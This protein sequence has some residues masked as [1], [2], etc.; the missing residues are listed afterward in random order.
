M[1]ALP[2]STLLPASIRCV[3]PV[4]AGPLG[5][6]EGMQADYGGSF[7]SL[8]ICWWLNITDRSLNMWKN[9]STLYTFS[10]FVDGLSI[11]TGWWFGTCFVFPIILGMSEPQLTNFIIFQRG[12]AQPPTRD[13]LSIFISFQSHGFS[14]RQFGIPIGRAGPC[15]WILTECDG[16]DGSFVFLAWTRST[17]DSETIWLVVSIIFHFP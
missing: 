7:S 12:G 14:V 9:S 5:C 13:G 2:I 4:K 6:P 15:S 3:G 10:N 17:Q 1:L 16:S 11:F 8:V